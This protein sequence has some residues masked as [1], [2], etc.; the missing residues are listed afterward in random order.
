MSRAV[1]VVR[2]SAIVMFV[3]ICSHLSICFDRF[4]LT[5][6]STTIAI[7]GYLVYLSR[8][9]IYGVTISEFKSTHMQDLDH[10]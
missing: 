5:T 4:R 6:T 3:F 8:E 1:Q 2:M 10:E 9:I 7:I